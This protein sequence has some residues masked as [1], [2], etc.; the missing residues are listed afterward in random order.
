MQ[1]QRQWRKHP[2][3]FT[4]RY[5]FMEAWAWEKLHLLSAIGNSV[6]DSKQDYNVLYVSSEQFTNEVVSAVRHGKTE[7]LK[8]KYR[9]VDLL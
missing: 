5:L 7:E 3:K 8:K 6:I 9:N 1:R 2:E 4:T